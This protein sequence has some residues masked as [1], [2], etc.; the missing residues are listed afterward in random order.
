MGRRTTPN[1]EREYKRLP[2]NIQRQ[3]DEALDLFAENRWQT[4]LNYKRP[5]KNKDRCTIRVNNKYRM[6][7]IFEGDFRDG[8]VMWYSVCSHDACDKKISRL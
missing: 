8:D 7:G 1:F 4:G 6:L 2:R 3:V 5:R